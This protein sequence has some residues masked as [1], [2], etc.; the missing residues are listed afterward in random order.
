M[1]LLASVTTSTVD[2]K[3]YKFYFALAEQAG[4]NWSKYPALT[5]VNLS[6]NNIIN[7]G[8]VILSGS[9]LS[10]VS[11]LDLDGQVLTADDQDLFLNGVAIA[12]ICALPNLA[13]WASYPADSNV[14]LN[15]VGIS[16]QPFSVIGAKTYT[17][18]DSSVLSVN[19]S[20]LLFNGT[21]IG[22]LL[23]TSTLPTK[24]IV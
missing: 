22:C 20:S 3:D 15:N 10:G 21:P 4:S 12:T 7:G 9:T 5:T 23:Y 19:A 13:E 16:G 18:S 1:S 11:L 24:R 8:N 2:N 6:G 14:E 17:F